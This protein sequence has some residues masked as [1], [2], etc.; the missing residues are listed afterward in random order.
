MSDSDDVY[1]KRGIDRCAIARCALFLNDFFSFLL[2][3]LCFRFAQDDVQSLKK[4][5]PYWRAVIAFDVER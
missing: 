4:G 5:V 1:A 3:F 2:F